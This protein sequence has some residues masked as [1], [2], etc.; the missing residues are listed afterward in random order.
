MSA[1]DDQNDSVCFDLRITF[2]IV[3]HNLFFHKPTN[4]GLSSDYVSCFHRY[5]TNR[6]SSVRISG[7]LSCSYSV[8]SGVTEG[9]TS[10]PLLFN[11]FI[12][13]V[14]DFIHHSE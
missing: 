2:D 7:T 9:S 3:E 12:S 13:Y 1:Q 6:Q 10:R 4:F 14:C 8:K 11:I 5:L